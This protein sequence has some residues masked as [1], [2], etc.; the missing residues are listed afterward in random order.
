[1]E[2]FLY[3][4][5]LT[6]G[7]ERMAVNDPH[8]WTLTLI[9]VTV[10]FVSLIILFCIYGLMGEI[11]MGTFKRKKKSA[12]PGSAKEAPEDSEVAAA[13]GLALDLYISENLH[14]EEPGVITIAPRDNTNW[15]F[16]KR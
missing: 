4:A 6:A 9:S 8:G 3:S 1:M 11:F 15:K 13:I 7:A 2:T 10:V 16:G 12:V 14:D 5:V